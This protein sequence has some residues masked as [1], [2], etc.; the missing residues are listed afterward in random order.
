MSLF[1]RSSRHVSLAA[2]AGAALVCTLTLSATPAAAA[3]VETWDKVAHCESTDNWQA[4]TGNGYYGGLQISASTW[5]A[6]GGQAYAA[7]PHQ[8]TKK[9]QILIAE[10]I[11]AGQGAGAWACAPGTGLA[12]DTAVPYPQGYDLT[13]DG[14]ADLIGLETDG[15]LTLAVGTGDG[16]SN[17]HTI[18]TGFGLHTKADRLS[19]VDADGDGKADLIGLET[20]GSLTLATGSGNGFSNYH[21]I[22]SGYGKFVNNSRLKFADVTGDGKADILAVEDDGTITMGVGTG[23]GFKDFH[24][25]A[26]G[27][28]GYLT[29]SRLKFADVTGDGKADLVALETNGSLTLAASNGDGFSNY[30]TISSGYGSYVNDDRL[31]L[32]DVTGD[33][34]AD[35]LAVESDGTLTLGVGTGNGFKDFHKV[36]SGFGGYV[37]DHRLQLAG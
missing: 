24:T 27:F 6:F 33:G 10:K 31:R 21:T 4:N 15:S 35:L 12:T 7:Y 9:Q 19:Y 14:K 30:H 16:F 23:N 22:S 36:A 11:L 28:G 32:G 17:Y 2:A 26:S 13:G 1:P 34:K 3:S 25:I 20:D 18:A 8:A 5:N 37:N 29:G